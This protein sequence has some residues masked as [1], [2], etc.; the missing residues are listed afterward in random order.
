MATKLL[1]F[2]ERGG[3]GFNIPRE[4]KIGELD[5]TN[6]YSMSLVHSAEYNRK[7]RSNAPA[8]AEY[9]L[10][11]TPELLLALCLFE[12]LPHGR[13]NMVRHGVQEAYQRTGDE[14]ARALGNMLA[15]AVATVRR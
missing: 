10:E 2:P 9:R 7:H 1:A 3:T 6:L 4:T 12:Q 14:G 8:E 11:R 15:A 5:L 13:K